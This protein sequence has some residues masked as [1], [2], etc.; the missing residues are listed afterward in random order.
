MHNIT[1]YIFIAVQ[2]SMLV[3]HAFPYSTMAQSIDMLCDK[4]CISAS[5]ETMKNISF[6]N[7]LTDDQHHFILYD[8]HNEHVIAR[9]NIHRKIIPASVIK[10]FTASYA[11]RKLGSDFKFVTRLGVIRKETPDGSML[12]DV[13]IVGGAD[14]VLDNTSL[15]GLI[16]DF[17]LSQDAKHYTTDNFFYVSPD[18]N[19]VHLLSAYQPRTASYNAGISGLNLNFNRALAAWNNQVSD[20]FLYLIAKGDKLS[21]VIPM[22]K[23]LFNQ[24][25]I[26]KYQSLAKKSHIHGKGSVWLPVHDSALYTATV[27]SILMN[28]EGLALPTPLRKDTI[29]DNIQFVAYHY[30]PPLRKILNDMLLYSTNTTAEIVGA[31]AA[32]S[33]LKQQSSNIEDTHQHNKINMMNRWTNNFLDT[34]G[35][36]SITLHNFSGLSAHASLN[37]ANIF[38]FLH[39]HHNEAENILNDILP[40]MFKEIFT[41]EKKDYLHLPAKTGS[42]H[43]ARSIAGYIRVHNKNRYIFVISTHNSRMRKMIDKSG[44]YGGRTEIKWLENAQQNEKDILKQW[45]SEYVNTEK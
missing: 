37:V 22:S 12:N 16:K 4:E 35:N 11:L 31:T 41:N 18:I 7:K 3:L 14:P 19:T 42:M 45:L 9:H 1:R 34:A 39:I 30:S 33:D 8:L 21:T 20:N 43:Y 29:P 44:G 15:H 40:D 26:D 10:A 32:T 36:D 27:F 13:Y 6:I 17:L 24:E 28:K 2:Y 5:S 23:Q 38:K 25:T